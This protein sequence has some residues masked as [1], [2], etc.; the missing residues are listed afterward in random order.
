MCTEVSHFRK[1]PKNWR[2]E[3]LAIKLSMA[4]YFLL[5]DLATPESEEKIHSLRRNMYFFTGF[6]LSH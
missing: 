6:G 4:V 1:I 3:L 2:E 5:C